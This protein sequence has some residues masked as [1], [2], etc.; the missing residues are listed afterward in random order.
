MRGA[1]RLGRT[2]S[3]R[4]ARAPA[5]CTAR[6]SCARDGDGRRVAYVD[7]SAG[8]EIDRDWFRAAGMRAS[9]SH[10]VRLPRRARP[11]RARRPG[12]AG[13]RA[14]VRRATRCARPRA[15]RA[16]PTPPRAAALTPLAPRAQRRRRAR[17]ARRSG[18]S[19]P[20]R[21]VDLWMAEAA[22]RP[23]PTRTLAARADRPRARGASPAPPG[24]RSTRRCGRAG[25]RP[26]ATGG[27]LDRA[28]RDLRVFLLQHRL[29]PLLRAPGARRPVTR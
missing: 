23:T 11:R 26:L 4:S 24:A 19:R 8:V 27:A 25:S 10:R 5:A 7:L 15:G 14:V 2:A 16:W 20:T 3:R 1:E 29:D 13:A 28:A 17:R 22:A 6:W 21:D 9:E 18:A 12:R